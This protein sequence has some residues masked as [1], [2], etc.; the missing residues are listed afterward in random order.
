MKITSPLFEAFLKCPTQCH[1]RS[2]GETGSGNAYA[3]WVRAQD[4]SYERE[5]MR[6]LQEGMPETERVVAP[7]A[8]ENLK[9]AKWRVATDVPVQIELRSSRG[10]EAQTSSPQAPM[11]DSQSND[12]SLLTSAA[13]IVESR[14]HAV[15]RIPSEGRGKPAQFIPIRF[16]FRNKLT[17]DDRLLLA[18]DALVLSLVLGREMRLGKITHGDDHATLKVK[19]GARTAESART[20][21]TSKGLAAEVRKRIE[22]MTTL[23]SSP[24][25][26]RSADSF[27]RA[28]EAGGDETRG[29]SGPRSEPAPPDLVLNRHCAECEFQARCRKIAVEKD[30]L[31][32]LAGMSEK[33]RERHR[34]KGIFT[35]TQ[36]SYT[37]RPR[38]T[39]KRA[40][41]P[42]K[43]RYLALQALAIRE[44]TVYIHGTPT[45]PQSKTRVY[46]DI[47]G[48]PDRDFHYLIGILVVSDGHETFHSFWADTQAD[49]PAIFAQ[50]ADAIS[51]LKDFRVFHFGDYDTAS[52]RRMKPRLSES[53]QKQLDVILGKCT[54]VLSALYPHVYFPTYSNSLK[55]IG[56]LVSVDCPTQKASGL[57]S[58]VWRTEWEAQQEFDLKAK[59]VEYNRTDCIILKRLSDFVGRQKTAVTLEGGN[60]TNVIHTQ[61]TIRDRPHWRMFGPKKYALEELGQINKRAYFDYQ[62]EK[63]LV[64]THKHFKNVNK[65]HRKL[66]KTN[67][68][69]NETIQIEVKRCPKCGSKKIQSI[70]DIS[71]VLLDLKFSRSGVKKWVKDARSRRYRCLKC[72]E[73][74]SSVD[75]R[76]N[77]QRHGHGLA[78]WAL[79][80]NIGCGLNMSR[81]AKSLGE[82]FKI[83]VNACALYRLRGYTVRLYE[84]LYA[85]LLRII[86]REPVIHIDETTVHLSK[87]KNGYVWV[88]TSMDKVYY[89]YRPSREGAFLEEML[90]PFVGVLVSDFYAAYDSLP[91]EQQKCLAH[92]VRDIDDDLLKN[93]LDFEFKG[94]ATD[95]GSLLKAIVQTVDRYGL[96]KRH[97]HKHKRKVL[98]FLDSVASRKYLSELAAKYQKRFQKSGLKM[99]TFLD[100]EGV[101]WNNNNAEHAIKR[102]AK[103]RRDANGKFTEAS[104]REYLVMA[105]VLETCE[106]NNVSVLDFLLSKE[107]TLSGLFRMA[108]R[109][110]VPVADIPSTQ[111]SQ[112]PGLSAD[113]IPDPGSQP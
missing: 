101:P 17:Q 70:K 59:L 75:R 39:P 74:F 78:S 64:R 69:P 82:I 95:F 3:E 30:D 110:T 28:S 33:E 67:V 31:S 44:N 108:G 65:R 27:V 97:L 11:R 106:F 18:F 23:L 56:R 2:L 55:D 22:K 100:H 48:L 47:E 79:Y 14:L 66:R 62:R 51:Q 86:L 111:I 32:L 8:T 85:E 60:G 5:A 37:F 41:N 102:F 91:C 84:P 43:P 1:L 45:L 35:V 94:I 105:S 4:E 25:T 29:L 16:V 13:T 46:L 72:A 53:H 103:H 57:H 81:V 89:F 10:H 6:R 90:S 54:N 12:Q 80:L 113:V 61:E 7:P 71:H 98:H 73:L 92:L 50:F 109:K 52:L 68:R 24:T 15:E 76:G 77:P 63:V 34:S 107:T 112:P 42:A 96:K 49:E 36:L 87:G 83:Y 9:L 99:F 21:V 93:P 40:K 88:L 19:T 104:L 26:T 20:P 58:I 38:R